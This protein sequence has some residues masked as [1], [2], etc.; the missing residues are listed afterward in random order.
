M[1]T[2]HEVVN[3]PPPLA[4]Y[5]LAAA[6]PV[7][8]D[9]V[10]REGGAWALDLIDTYGRRMTSPEVIEWGFLANRHTPVLQTHD[11]FGHRLDR[12]D[13]HPS[14]HALI[15]LAVSNGL[16]SLPWERQPGEGGYVARSALTFLSSQIEA[17]HWCPVSMACSVIP[18][19]RQQPE[20]AAEWE[21]LQLRRVYDPSFLPASKKRGVML[22]MGMT[23]KQGGSDVRANTTNARPLDGGGP[24]AEYIL[25]GHKWFVSAP[26][27][28]AFLVLA[29]AP[30]GLSCFLLPRFTP[31]GAP[32][33]IYLQRLKDKLG[34]RS[35]A[36]SEAEFDG[37]WARMVG[38]E[39]RGVATIIEMVNG[40]RLDCV[41]GSAALMRQA[42]TQAIH[43]TA[44]RRAFGALLV[45]KPAMYNVLADLE[46]ETETAALLMMRVAGAFD[47]APLD[48]HE[49][50]VKRILTPVVKFWVTKRCTEVV[51]EA[52]ECLGGNGFVEESIMPRLFR[53]SPLNAI[54]EGSGNVIALDVIRVLA[55]EQG[56]V[57]ALRKELERGKGVDS[58]LDGAIEDA[59]VSVAAVAEP[60]YEARR[61]VEKLV[62][63]TGGVLA[64]LYARPEV[65]KAYAATRLGGGWGRLYG[66]LP[67]G[68]D[69][70][71]I[72]APA[73]PAT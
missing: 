55:K 52:T 66:T 61:L 16:H 33:R 31:D 54:W 2:T 6:D 11:R 25:T 14:W 62:T 19:L 22:G 4:D 57:E 5:D 46:V 12:V 69:A 36:S 13:Y 8:K 34:N 1:G 71:A 72:I 43:H 10:I 7:L 59:F 44:H 58:R 50:L 48:H 65:W 56:A 51:H 17:G 49:G 20:V 18:T 24:G 26:M 32:N 39:G 9:A 27:S 30:G 60:E 21:P 29:Q 53:E 64:A 67:R 37:A 63:A 42:I 15:D 35:N 41:I 68:I 45:D 3:Q 70:K 40:T 38:E 47:R 73:L 28:D 23:E